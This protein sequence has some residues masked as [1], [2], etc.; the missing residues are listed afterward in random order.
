MLDKSSLEPRKTLP[1]PLFIFELANNHMGDVEHGLRVISEFGAL[2]RGYDF[3]FA[4]K[5][6]FRELDSFIHPDFQNRTDIKYI[7]RFSETR[8]DRDATRRLTAAIKSEGF[9]AMCTPFDEASVDR[10]VEDGFDILK[11]ASCSFTDWPLLEKIASVDLPIIGSTAGIE[12]AD[13]DNV[14]A[15]M[16]HRDKDFA[17]MACVAR[18][19]TP[20]EALQLNQIDVLKE[21]YP[22]LRIGYSTH[23]DPGETVPV[24]MAIAK[25]AVLF[26]KHIG[27][28]TDAYPLNAYSAS[29]A[30][31]RAW[32]DAA[33][34][35][36][37]ICGVAGRR[38][39][40]SAAELAALR[41]LRRGAFAR[42]PIGRGERIR[43]EDVFFAIPTQP[44]QITANDWSKYTLFTA[45]EDIPAGAPVNEAATNR[46]HVR[47]KV[48]S[49]VSSVKKLLAESKGV[50]PGE[51]E[52]E[53]S[54][55]FG[56]ERF[57][58]YGITMVTVV[59][60]GYCKKLIVV[61]PG[62]RHPEQFHK[63]KEETFHVL[64]GELI[65]HLDGKERICGPGSVVTIAPG[66]RHA[67][68]TRT[69]AV[70]EEISSTHFANDSFYTDEAINK[71]PDR[72]TLLR[73]WLA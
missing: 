73:Y 71:N 66:V 3:S 43:T 68:E 72:K 40:P 44:G 60:R 49:I 20:H 25:G 26:E 27:V 52:L 7:K 35:A 65:L 23:E 29:P 48:F 51:A 56:L 67:F 19:P 1:E 13:M 55:H 10:I 34:R 46:E 4:F 69:G 37:E 54:H 62:Q 21:R 2:A 15:F 64:H 63:L 41:D 22:N 24:A 38:I 33:R 12:C 17:L 28:P 59:N 14:V 42:R 70:F 18:Y 31:A 8:L 11:I 61:L 6:Q 36:Y 9:L 45:A 50:V 5:L 39:E 16:R 58:E 57:E 53:I 30:Q 32:L 47:A